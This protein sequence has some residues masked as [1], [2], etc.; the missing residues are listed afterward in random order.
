LISNRQSS[1]R[2]RGRG[3]S[4]RSS[5]GSS[6]GQRDSGN[7]IDSRT[8]G[9][10]AQLLEKYRNMARDAQMSGDRVNT[11]YYLQFADHYFRVLSDSRARQDDH[12]PVRPVD[13]FDAMDEE[14]GDEGEPIRAGEQGSY[15]AG[16]A[17]GSDNRSD[18]NDGNR[19]DGNRQSGRDYQA[20]DDRQP[21]EERSS[22][23][24][25]SLRDDRSRDDRSRRDSRD[26][27]QQNGQR[28][29]QPRTEQPRA[30]QPRPP[31][32]PVEAQSSVNGTAHAT[33]PANDIDAAPAAAKPER[34]PRT[35]RSRSA[36]PARAPEMEVASMDAD[37]LPPSLG[38]V[39][40]AVAESEGEA[41]PKPKRRRSSRS[42]TAPEAQAS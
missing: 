14:Y 29:H 2:R 16:R 32:Q 35:S 12:R 23:D 6:Q 25:R 21:R 13:D 20:R 38:I 5:G 26:R 7:R 40:E 3:G 39:G 30:E 17:N 37:R 9:N 42:T 33:G 15:D 8:R 24:E 28:D 22:R 27:D 11:E 41:E 19:S 4:S 36:T 34:K 10:A 1:S 31:E 18:R